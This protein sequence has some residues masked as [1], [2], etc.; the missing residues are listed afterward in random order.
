MYHL[1]VLTPEEI[2]FEDDVTAL[3][4]PGEMGYL[5]ILTDHASLITTLKMGTLIITDQSQK[6]HFYKVTGGFLE[7]DHNQVVILVD[8]IFPT[9]PVNMGGGI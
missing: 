5:G 6:K 8:I 1:Q 3:I 9:E 4:A 2:I 7:V